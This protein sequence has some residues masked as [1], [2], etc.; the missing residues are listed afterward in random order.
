MILVVGR[1]RFAQLLWFSGLL[2]L[3][4]FAAGRPTHAQS[5]PPTSYL[6]VEVRDPAGKPVTDATIK[7]S[8]PDGQPIEGGWSGEPVDLKTEQ[9][10]L[11]NAKFLATT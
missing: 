6:F 11:V 5:I 9:S 8:T 2:V 7:V 10:G 1:I 4:F 3:I